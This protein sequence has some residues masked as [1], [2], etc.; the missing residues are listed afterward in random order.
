[1]F[2]PVFMFRMTT[3]LDA[4]LELIAHQC[5]N[6]IQTIESVYDALQA[7]IKDCSVD[8]IGEAPLFLLKKPAS[9]KSRMR[10]RRTGIPPFTINRSQHYH[11]HR[12]EHDEGSVAVVDNNGKNWCSVPQARNYYCALFS[13]HSPVWGLQTSE[14]LEEQRHNGMN[15]GHESS[16]KAASHPPAGFEG[17]SA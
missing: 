10:R 7:L 16:A 9:P 6:P 14:R 5:A 11:H 3:M 13:N 1:M 17:N 2:V 8:G 12:L 15:G 4:R